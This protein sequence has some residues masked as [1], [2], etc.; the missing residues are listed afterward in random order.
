MPQFIKESLIT[1][2]RLI[3]VG[4]TTCI[5]FVSRSQHG[6]RPS[7]VNRLPLGEQDDLRKKSW[8][9]R[10]VVLFHIQSPFTCNRQFSWSPK[11][12]TQVDASYLVDNQVEI[13]SVWPTWSMLRISAPDN[14]SF[15]SVRSTVLRREDLVS[16]LF[17]DSSHSHTKKSNHTCTQVHR[18]T[19]EKL[20]STEQTGAPWPNGDFQSMLWSNRNWSGGI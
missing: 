16:D 18:I 17:I 10:T 7:C 13:P 12:N 4:E 15:A 8:K 9:R 6:G 14:W 19:E 3:H 20:R 1:V 5:T 2:V 11:T